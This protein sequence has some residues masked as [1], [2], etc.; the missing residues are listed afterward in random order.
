MDVLPLVLRRKGEHLEHQVRDK[1][2]DQVLTQTGVQQRHINDADVHPLVFG[3]ELPLLLYLL[4]VAAQ[5]VDAQYVQH[6]PPA[7]PFQELEILGAVKIPSGPLVNIDVLFR[8]RLRLEGDLLPFLILVGAGYADI[9][10]APS[11][12]SG[13]PASSAFL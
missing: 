4:I 5:P 1:S 8:H 3:Q 13:P 11:L 7:Q 12:H 9:S 10:I 2:S 6:I